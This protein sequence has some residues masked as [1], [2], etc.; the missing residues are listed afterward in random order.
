M[1]AE[2]RWKGEWLASQWP[3]CWLFDWHDVATSTTAL[4]TTESGFLTSA[5]KQQQRMVVKPETAL[6]R[7]F[8]VC[9]VLRYVRAVGRQPARYISAHV[10]LRNKGRLGVTCG[11]AKPWS[12]FQ[13]QDGKLVLP[14]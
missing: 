11:P 3:C 1:G 9:A 2:R 12:A 14:G 7:P 6:V 5:G 4:L 10:G 13:L 8:V